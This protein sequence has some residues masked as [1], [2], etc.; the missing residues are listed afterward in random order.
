MLDLP[1]SPR[2]TISR[3]HCRRNITDAVERLAISR[4][5]RCANLIS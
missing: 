5:Y 2:F 1:R 3:R 4:L